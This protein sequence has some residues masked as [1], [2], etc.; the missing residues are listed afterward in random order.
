MG[1]LD[2]RTAARLASSARRVCS[3]GWRFARRWPVIPALILGL[4]AI[5]AIFAPLLSPQDPII[6]SLRDRAAP[7]AWYTSWYEEHPKSARRYI[8]GADQ[9]GRD[10]LSRIIYG[11]RISLIVATT[12]LLAGGIVGISVGLVSGFAG[13]QTDEI[14]MRIVDISRA[15]PYILIA[16][17]IVIALGQ[18]LG[19]MV[20]IVAWTTWGTFAR[21]VRAEALQLKMMDYIALARVSGAS[22]IRVMIRH[23]LPGLTNTIMVLSTLQ[24]GSLI[25][26]EAILSFL[27][28]GIPPPTPAWGAMIADGRDYLGSAWWIAFFPGMAIFLTVLALNFLGDWLRDRFDP[29]LRQL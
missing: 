24:V 4:L 25:L 19:V 7:P 18:G 16:L 23:I 27:G 1:T 6:S 2:A 15:I 3:S 26:F 11:S 28:A 5:S 13:G 10:L 17:V 8:L 9:M 14:L 29:R 20:A 22:P 12:A 21:Q